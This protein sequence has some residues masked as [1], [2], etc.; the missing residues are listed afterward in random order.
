MPNHAYTCTQSSKRQ[1]AE[2][3]ERRGEV[4]RGAK[5]TGKL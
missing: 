3:E 1:S 5:I 2:R 4:R